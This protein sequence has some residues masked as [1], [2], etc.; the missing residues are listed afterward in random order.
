MQLA[1]LAAGGYSDLVRDR[2]GD[3]YDDIVQLY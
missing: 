2:G 3:E 1:N